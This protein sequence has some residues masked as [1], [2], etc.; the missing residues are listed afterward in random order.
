MSGSA[1]DIAEDVS[2]CPSGALQV[3]RKDGGANEAPDAPAFALPL[4]NRP[5]YVRGDIKILDAEGGVLGDGVRFALCRCAGSANK[6]FC[7]TPTAATA[8]APR[9][10]RQVA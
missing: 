6:P 4:P 10:G 8:S 3:Q 2:L 9:S 5:T 7:A 1:G